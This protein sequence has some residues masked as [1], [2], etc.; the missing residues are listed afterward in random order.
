[1]EY[2]VL[3]S[4][5]VSR[6]DGPLPLGGPKQR[7]LLALLLVNANR[8]VARGPPHRRAV[9]REPSRHG[10]EVDAGLRVALA[11]ALARGTLLTRAPGYLLARRARRA[12]P[13]AVRAAR[14]GGT[15]HGSRRRRLDCC[16]RRSRCG[17]VLR[18]P[19]STSRSLE[20]RAVGS[21]ICGLRRSRNASRP[22]CCSAA[23]RS[24]SAS[25][26]RSSP[27]ARTAS[28]CAPS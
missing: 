11:E 21:K 13:R 16:A 2:R 28:V 7:A 25:S 22:T 8:V 10:G 4:L 3:G 24:S 1:M 19:S 18:S 23:M 15:R 27:R 6:G 26:R 17:E 9:G 14:H 12:R 20:R 5:E